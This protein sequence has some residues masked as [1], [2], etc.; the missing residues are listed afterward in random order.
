MAIYVIIIAL[1]IDAALH[2]HLLTPIFGQ[3]A[4]GVTTMCGASRFHPSYVFF[5]N[6]IWPTIT[7]LTVTI[8]PGSCMLI[9]V[10]AIAINVKNS[11]N[12]VVAVDN[13]AQQ[14]EKRR[15]RFLHR[16]MLILMLIT[17]I[18]FFLTTFPVAVFRFA[19]S[20]LQVQQSFALSLLLAS[21]FSLITTANYSLNFYL[22]CLTS[23][24][25][26]KE[27][28]KIF[29][30]TI[31]ITFGQANTPAAQQHLMRPIQ[32]GTITQLMGYTSNSLAVR[33]TC[34]TSV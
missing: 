4:P 33:K 21:I 3:I 24:L 11:R 20:T 10:L 29:P 5:Y 23:K 31:S 22:H 2:S 25:F 17:V 6:N 12:R 9:F 28:S 7:I 18:M 30:C 13:P 8:L 15:A 19:F 1:I 16:Q 32:G 26:R 14:H 27:F 34:D